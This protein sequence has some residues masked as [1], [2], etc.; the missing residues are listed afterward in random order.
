LR[1]H[2]RRRFAEQ[3]EPGRELRQIV[4]SFLGQHESAREPVEQRRVEILLEAAHLLAHCGSADV[5][6]VGGRD[7]AA[8]P[9]GGLESA[10]RI[11]R[12][13]ASGHG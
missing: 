8:E 7:E 13:E 10:Q 4:A 12:R 9:R 11:E 2:A 1:A 5:Q 6:L 3:R